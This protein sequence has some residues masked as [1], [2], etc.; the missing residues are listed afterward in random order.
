[1]SV[2][3]I[4][5]V[6]P[7]S[8]SQSSKIS[9]SPTANPSVSPLGLSVPPKLSVIPPP[10]IPSSPSKPPIGVNHS[11][12]PLSLVFENKVVGS[13]SQAQSSFPKTLSEKPKDLSPTKPTSNGVETSKT[14]P[15]NPPMQAFSSVSNNKNEEA[16]SQQTTVNH[17]EE[18]IS[19]SQNQP[20]PVV[21]EPS[22]SSTT[23]A[24]NTT[25]EK[26]EE[27]LNENASKA[28]DKTEI[29]P[30]NE[31]KS[32]K[33]DLATEVKVKKTE[34]K[35][36]PSSQ[37]VKRKREQKPEEKKESETTPEKKTRRIRSQVLPYQSPLPELAT[38]INK[39]LKEKDSSQKNN[40]EKLIVFYRY[41]C[42]VFIYTI[43]IKVQMQI[44]Y[45]DILI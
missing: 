20:I 25:P 45:M 43:S 34:A 42:N 36:A 40:D 30:S 32:P 14:P 41:E 3:A 21:E 10:Q 19:T 13:Q 29:K 38:F 18:R 6:L 1:M 5:S 16:S 9:T 4:N 27:S 28:D 23:Q 12:V 17:T 31:T 22:Q 11:A 24:I 8:G 35:T 2:P 44:H 15:Q 39:S 37:P 26:S 33:E 7:P